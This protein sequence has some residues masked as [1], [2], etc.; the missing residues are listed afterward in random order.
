MGITAAI[1]GVGAL[2]SAGSAVNNLVQ[3]VSGG[4]SIGTA[5][6]GG[7]SAAAQLEAGNIQ[8]DAAEKALAQQ[9]TANKSVTNTFNPLTG[10]IAPI[11]GGLENLLG[12][13]AQGSAGMLAQ[14]QATPG[15]QFA[16]EQGLQATQS[17]FAAQGLAKSG[18]ALKGA[19][20]YAEGLAGTTYQNMVSNFMN[21]GTLGL[22]AASA[23]GGLALSGQNSANSL[24]LNSGAAKAS[25]LVGAANVLNGTIGNI[26]ALNPNNYGVGTTP[27]TSSG[28]YD[29]GMV[30]R[31]AANGNAT[32][33]NQLALQNPYQIQVPSI[34]PGALNINDNA[35]A[36]PSLPTG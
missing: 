5:I 10:S 23:Q 21:G 35:F 14:L 30:D 25:G 28:M 22:N 27:G 24:I 7:V 1:A 13:G 31:L 17:G 12:V 16:K 18:A 4:A 34:Q 20:N 29:S 15:Y 9:L 33:T 6:G 19:A 11:T 32:T 36:I 3:G 2:A 8:H 26:N